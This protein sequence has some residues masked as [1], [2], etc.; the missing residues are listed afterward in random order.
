MT[1]PNTNVTRGTEILVAYD[2]SVGA[3]Q[4]LLWAA[5]LAEAQKR[6]LRV[7]VA[8]GDLHRVSAWADEWTRGLAAEWVDQARQELAAHE[9]SPATYEIAD[10]DTVPVILAR[11]P[12]VATV[13][14]GSRGR[15]RL[16]GAL[17]GSVSQQ[18]VRHALA[19]V[20]VVRPATQ[21]MS[22][23]VYVGMDGS[24]DGAAALAYALEVAE[25]RGMSLVVLH[26]REVRLPGRDERPNEL[27]S[28]LLTEQHQRGR[29]VDEA[30]EAARRAYPGVPIDLR[31]TNTDP[32]DALTR[33]SDRAALVVV[34][35]R[36]RH[37]FA[38]M[39]LGSV[40]AAV[41]THARCSVAVVR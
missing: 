15:S 35:S 36:G 27:R 7:V 23:S 21:P 19:P 40:S 28:L 41:L 12:G 11:S 9:L 20:V 10:G 30:V 18:V 26:S 22:N 37:P 16:G 38:G 14:L 5:G 3:G 4:A 8:R 33:A 29:R 6:G 31:L 25:D 24:E 13:V 1:T 17:L 39:L 32:A 34:G 2:G